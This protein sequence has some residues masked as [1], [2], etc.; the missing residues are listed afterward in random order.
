MVRRRTGA[1]LDDPSPTHP[2]APTD[3]RNAR[4]R[5]ISS[6][7]TPSRGL[8]LLP[9]I[10]IG[11]MLAGCE[12]PPLSDNGVVGVIGHEGLRDG[13]FHYPRAVT[14]EP[15]GSVFVVDKTGRIQRFDRDGKFET[16]WRMPEIRAG[17]PV[18]IYMHTDG[19]L[20]IADT[21][22][23][24]VLITDRDGKTLGSF[25][26][27]GM[28]EGEFQLPTDVAVDADGY[29]Y[30]SEYHLTERVSKWTPD[31]TFIQ[32][33]GDGEVRGKR[34][35][36]P[37]AIEID[38][39]QTLWVADAC[40]H[41]LI[42]FT[43]DGKV[44]AVVGGFGTEPG[45]LKYPYDV[46]M[47]PDG[48]LLV[49]EY[50]NNRLQWLTKDGRSLGVWGTDGRKVGQLFAP[51]G[52]VYGPGGRVYVVDAMNNRVQVIGPDGL[53]RQTAEQVARAGG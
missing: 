35:G 9:L 17:K 49:C 37:S 32:F 26:H 50:G 19:R 29:I 41:R 15:D 12:P 33:I 36:R 21:H 39:E 6:S 10:A 44:L 20:F 34:M 14:A 2:P 13:E 51:W 25:G 23:H 43:L 16:A 8:F 47:T 5:P 42:R 7:P 45:K 18:G 30:V 22:Y 40:N 46:T 24:R 48:N 53:P 11:P 38:D 27:E 4:T 3:N 52:A 1:K 28:G 31:F